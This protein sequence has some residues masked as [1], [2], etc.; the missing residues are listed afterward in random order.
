MASVERRG[1]RT[2][3]IAVV[4]AGV[5]GRWH[6]HAASR[7]GARIRAVVDTDETAARA[8]AARTVPPA[9][10]FRSLEACLAA[11]PVEVVHVCTPL[12]S[13]VPIVDAALAAGC[14]VLAEKPLAPTPAETERLLEGASAAGVLLGAVH[15]FPF[16]PGFRRLVARR[17]GLGELVR[18][19]YRTCSAGGTGLS[20]AERRKLLLEI[21]PHPAS[22]FERLLPGGFDPD[23]LRLLGAGDDDLSLAGATSGTA[24]DIFIT[25][26]GRPTANELHVVG[27]EG[28]ALV[29]LF[30]GYSVVDRA[31]VSRR[32]K[33]M[34][35]FRL[36][37]RTLVGATGNLAVRARRRE[38]AYP[39]LRALI[40][41][42]Y[43]ALP[44]GPAPVSEAELRAAARLMAV[45]RG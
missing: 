15:Q 24:L 19:S 5:M 44:D 2:P 21:L 30:H 34:R 16:Q 25:L 39:G 38:P 23:S 45:A 40:E 41:R 11:C 43:E 33:A 13:H 22:L 27:T 31:G 18:V 10:T 35:P 9:A 20:A 4:G 14:H 37:T 42:F 26:R 17:A 8:L 28:S 3:G 7:L 32:A 12:A 6:A 1:S 36:G 29:D